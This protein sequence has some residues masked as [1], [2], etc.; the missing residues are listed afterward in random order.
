[1]TFR[2]SKLIDNR[3]SWHPL[4]LRVKFGSQGDEIGTENLFQPSVQT[5]SFDV[6]CEQALLFGRAKLAARERASER[7]SREGQAR[8]AYPNRRAC[9]QAMLNTLTLK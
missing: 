2:K 3:P 9:S 6:A 7:R 4:R 1:M 8:F 5:G